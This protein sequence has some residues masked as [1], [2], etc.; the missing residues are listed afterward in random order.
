MA[1]RAGGDK[2][3]NAANRRARKLWMLSQPQWQGTGTVLGES[4]L[5]ALGCGVVVTFATVEADRV[6]PGGSYRRENV[7]PACRPCNLAKSD[8]VVETDEIASRVARTFARTG[9]MTPAL[10]VA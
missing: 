8:D 1:K 9:R 6:I 2:R 3:G 10:A 7:Q 5:C 4:A